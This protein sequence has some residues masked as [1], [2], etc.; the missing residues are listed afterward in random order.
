MA[1]S[2]ERGNPV[3]DGG[4]GGGQGGVT[5]ATACGRARVRARETTS[6]IITPSGCKGSG[7]CFLGF[8][9]LS[10]GGEDWEQR[11][12]RVERFKG[13]GLRVQGL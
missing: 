10:L 12:L 5:H 11:W 7:V 13:L 1:V 6:K 2:Y 3:V 9:I 8:G 4:S